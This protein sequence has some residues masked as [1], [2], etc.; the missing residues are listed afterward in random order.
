MA[1]WIGWERESQGRIKKRKDD[2]IRPRTRNM[3]TEKLRETNDHEGTRQEWINGNMILMGNKCMYFL[4]EK[5]VT[6][7]L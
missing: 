4:L 6:V 3:D 2:I 7:H 5:F 1:G